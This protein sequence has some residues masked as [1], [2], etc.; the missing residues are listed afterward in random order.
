MKVVSGMDE[1]ALEEI[2]KVYEMV[3]EAGVYKAES[4]KVLKRLR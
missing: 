2:A 3:V 4:T 1:E